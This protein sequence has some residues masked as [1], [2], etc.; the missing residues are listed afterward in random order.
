MGLFALPY[1]V[2]RA[3]RYPRRPLYA[4]IFAN[5]QE[6]RLAVGFRSR[7]TGHPGIIFVGTPS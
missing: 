3:V 6:A 2:I 5:Q 4:P 7:L 1:A